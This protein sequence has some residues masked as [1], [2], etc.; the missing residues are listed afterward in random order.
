MN[1]AALA[2]ARAPLPDSTGAADRA[3]QTEA[4]EFVFALHS[5]TRA[6]LLYPIENQTVQ[7]ALGELAAAARQL[8]QREG[9]ITLRYIDDLCFVNDL[10]LRVDLSSYATFSGVART[11]QR[12]GVGQIEV[13]AGADEGE[14][15]ALLSL[16]GSEPQ[17][18]HPFKALDEH[19]ER[20]VVRNISVGE[21]LENSQSPLDPASSKEIAKRTFTQS[22][23]AVREVMTGVRMGKGLSLRRVKRSV[24]LIVDQVLTNETSIM[25]MTALREYDDYTFTHSVNVCIFSVAL[26]KKLGLKRRQ[27]YELGLGALMHDIGKLRMPIEVITKPGGLTDQEWALIQ[28]H[29]AE[30]LLS[31]FDMQNF[32]ELPLRAMLMAY[33]HHMKRDLS[34]YPLSRRPREPGLFSRIVA[35]ADGFDAATSK[36]SYQSQPGTPD[37]VLREMREN[38]ARGYDPLLVKAFISMTGIYP[39]GTVVILDTFEMAVVIAPGRTPGAVGQPTVRILY[40]DLGVPLTQPLT[41]DLSDPNPPP[42]QPKRAIIKATD[43]DRYGIDVTDC[44]V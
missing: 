32:T 43:A 40:D 10:R 18:E 3:L 33:E 35:I 28:E 31:L 5:A 15:T 16:L 27:L 2:G 9:S 29:P 17:S 34:G 11:L 37:D 23:A 7:N 36:R 20:S 12:H 21:L 6:L 25:G 22:V 1:P 41:V 24:Q 39:V 19:L 13:A 44:F 8:Q 4:R 14:W 30:G 26:G 42:G 38:P